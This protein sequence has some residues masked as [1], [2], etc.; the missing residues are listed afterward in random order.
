M[1]TVA[2]IDLDDTL[3]RSDGSISART[4]DALRAWRA[5]GHRIVIATG[6]PRRTIDTVL[7]LELSDAPVI[8]YNGAEIYAKGQKLYD[9][10]I[11][12]A[13]ARTIVERCLALAPDAEIGVEIDNV[14]YLNR[15]SKRPR[16]YEVADLLEL[17]HQPCAKVLVFADELAV[18]DPLLAE[19]PAGAR[20][21]H[22]G[23]YRF[24]QILGETVDKAEALRFLVTDWGLTMANVV[25]FGDDTN[26]VDMVRMSGLGVAMSNA[27]EEVLAVAQRVTTTNDEDGV[28][29]VLEELLNS[30]LA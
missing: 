14:L 20:A 17:T 6:R 22:S 1:L 23:R 25:A 8:S 29:L 21:L 2:A 12:A 18:L 27:V 30:S 7:P 13:A 16:L 9:N 3:L 10:L 11:P 15:P 19:L 4:L 26:D 28:A 24:L 5:K